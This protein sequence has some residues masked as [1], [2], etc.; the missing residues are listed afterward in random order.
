MLREAGGGPGAL[1]LETVEDP[2]P[3]AGEVSLGFRTT[4]RISRCWHYG[5]VT[6]SG[7]MLNFH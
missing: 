5:S 7:E 1:R 2:V 3:G 6:I 4:A